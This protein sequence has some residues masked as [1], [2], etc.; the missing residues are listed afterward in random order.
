M[1]DSLERKCSSCLVRFCNFSRT[2]LVQAVNLTPERALISRGWGFS[3]L[4]Q[5][6]YICDT[7]NVKEIKKR[8]KAM[9]KLL[10]NNNTALY[11]F[12]I[13]TVI[14]AISL[15]VVDW[16]VP[17]VTIATFGAAIAAAISLGLVNASIKPFLSLLSLP[18]TI[19]SL[20][21]F[22]LVI[23]GFCFWLASLVVSGFTVH[24]LFGFLLGPVVLSFVSTALTG[25]FYKK[26]LDKKLAEL[27]QK[28]NLT[29]A[30][31]PTV[32]AYRSEYE[33]TPSVIDVTAWEVS[34]A[35]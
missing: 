9:K 27:G 6:N 23:N 12:V 1:K 35:S 29:S 19:L 14:T 18:V 16:T 28:L 22:G 25:Y 3:T 4:W 10:Q 24:G 33:P 20:G 26:G 11:G 15:L 8:K 7:K 32:S 13:T 5:V 31:Q 30:Q 21:S 2:V 17:G 34:E